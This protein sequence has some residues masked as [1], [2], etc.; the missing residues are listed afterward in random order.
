M[1]WI[2]PFV[3]ALLMAAPAAA[4]GCSCQPQ[5]VAELAPHLAVIFEGTVVG[6]PTQV[7]VTSAAAVNARNAYRF[8]VRRVWKGD[9]GPVFS[10]AYPV[11]DWAN[12]GVELREGQTLVVGANPYREP[13]LPM[14][15]DGCLII[16]MNPPGVDPVRSLGPPRLEHPQ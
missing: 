7:P 6:R 12:C 5:S 2:V 3:L 14:E 11:R 9:V 4:Q 1:R 13:G 8:M 10:V 15:S 16:N